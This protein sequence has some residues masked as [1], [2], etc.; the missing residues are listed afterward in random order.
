LTL[1]VPSGAG[2]T[3]Q[4]IYSGISQLCNWERLLLVPDNAL[5]RLS[6]TL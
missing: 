2:C 4:A 3:V 6:A 5:S 1:A